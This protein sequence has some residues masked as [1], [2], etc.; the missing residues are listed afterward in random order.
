[1]T[2]GVS[3]YV[4]PN[5]RQDKECDSDPTQSTSQSHRLGKS[6]SN[7]KSDTVRV[8]HTSTSKADLRYV[9]S[10]VVLYSWGMIQL[11]IVSLRLLCKVLYSSMLLIAVLL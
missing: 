7:K 4:Q 9:I 11:R 10:E 3:L 2:R 8:Q 5:V 6:L 1:M